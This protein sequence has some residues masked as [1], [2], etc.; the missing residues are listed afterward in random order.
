ME[1]QMMKN[2]L[3]SQFSLLV[4]ANRKWKRGQPAGLGQGRISMQGNDRAQH[5][6]ELPRGYRHIRSIEALM[7]VESDWR[8]NPKD[9]GGSPDRVLDRI[10]QA[11]A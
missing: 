3:Y 2:K 10:L 8:L 7:A 9:A 11:L 6:P 5:E 1:E 4:L